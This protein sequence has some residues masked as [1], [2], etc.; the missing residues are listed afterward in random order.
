M[1]S[2]D[3][4]L[5]AIAAALAQGALEAVKDTATDAVKAAYGAL[6]HALAKHAGAATQAVLDKPDSVAK[7]Q[8][9]AEDLSDTDDA[10]RDELRELVAALTQAL[11]E[12]RAIQQF[13]LQDING[14]VN[15]GGVVYG[16]M[17]GGDKLESGSTKIDARGSQGFVNSNSGTVTQSFGDRIDTGGGAF[18]RGNVSVGGDFV[19]RDKIVNNTGGDAPSQT[20][21][22]PRSA[23]LARQMAE[24][25]TPDDLA[26]IAAELGVDAAHID[27]ETLSARCRALVRLCQR[28]GK[29]DALEQLIAD[30]R[31]GTH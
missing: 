13:T 8:S 24:L 18:V 21:L 27:G 12:Q 17:F 14:L 3:P 30:A 31:P 1:T 9:L 6:K 23:R 20:A 28:A 10:T 7:Q 25:F 19:G 16:G 22:P 4:I 15:A 5:T 2:P 29:L 26:E 11:A